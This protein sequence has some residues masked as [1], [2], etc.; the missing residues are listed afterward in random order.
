MGFGRAVLNGVVV[1]VL[2]CG[3]SATANPDGGGASSPHDG[4]EGAEDPASLNPSE[5][6]VSGDAGDEGD[7]AEMVVP[8]RTLVVLASGQSDPLA[9]ALDNASVYWAN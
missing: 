6:D 1:G 3:G 8:R 4:E 2:G 5:T 9:I 7:D